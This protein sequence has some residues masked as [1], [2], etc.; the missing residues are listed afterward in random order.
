MITITK[1]EYKPLQKEL[2]TLGHWPRTMTNGDGEPG[3]LSQHQCPTS[4]MNL[5]E[6]SHTHKKAEVDITAKDW[7]TSYQTLWINK[8]KMPLVNAGMYR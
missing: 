6:N 7:P 4:Q 2:K 5:G 1:T 3:L 8:Y